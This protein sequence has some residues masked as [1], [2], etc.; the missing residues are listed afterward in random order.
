M[1]PIEADTWS[2]ERRRC[3]LLQELAHVK[4]YDC[5]SQSFAQMAC[6][7]N[8]YNPLVWLAARHMRIE[9]EKACDDFVLRGGVAPSHT[10]GICSTSRS[11]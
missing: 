6:A 9:R 8:W 1:L 11:K 5:V 2:Q 3:V 7:F 10:L 4:R